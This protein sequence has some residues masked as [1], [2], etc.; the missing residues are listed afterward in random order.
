M[1]GKS[2][3]NRN[4]IPW[5]L[6]PI[7]W[8]AAIAA[9]I[10]GMLE[11]VAE[12]APSEAT[13]ELVVIAVAPVLAMLRFKP[14]LKL[15]KPPGR[16]AWISDGVWSIILGWLSLNVC[17]YIGS[18]YAELPP[19][20]H[21]EFSYLFQAKTLLA[22]RFSFPSH[23]VHPELFNQMHV[24]NEGRMA[25]RYYPG[26]GLWLAPFVAQ[27]HPYLAPAIAGA[28]ATV[29]VFWIGKEI[30]G[31][32]AGVVAGGVLAVS[33]GVTV[34]GNTLLAH[35]PT[36]LGE[37]LFLLG[38]TRWRRTR[39][40]LDAWMAGIGLS[41]AM[42]CRPLTAAAIGL[43]FGIDIALWLIR[44]DA[45][46]RTAVSQELPPP[47]PDHPRRWP[48]ILG[49]AAPLALGW[50]TMLAYN[51]DITGQ[52]LKSPYQLYTDVYTPRHVFGFNN[53]VRGEKQ[54]GPKV[55]DEYD[56][57]AENLGWRLAVKNLMTRWTSSW[58]WTLGFVPLLLTT[59]FYLG[60]SRWLDR[61]WNLIAASIVSLHVLHLPYWFVGL[62]GWHYVF[63]S[64]PL[65]CLLLG[66][67]TSLL[68]S[69]WKRQGQWLLIGWWFGIIG[70][71]LAGSYLS[72][73]P[74]P[75]WPKHLW[76]SRV[77]HGMNILEYPRKRHFEQRRWMEAHVGDEPALVL[78]DQKG[79]DLHMDMV[80]NDPGLNGKILVGRYFEGKTDAAQIQRDFPDRRVYVASPIQGIFRPVK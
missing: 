61:R 6:P 67:I 65:W 59:V 62:M 45:S 42:L 15:P 48:T 19:A 7:A 63:E 23:P 20:Y 10:L 73:I 40:G 34:F 56:R 35:H 31:R 36:L 75:D 76:C 49:F 78:W 44:G 22:G 52:W 24:L 9:C 50:G 18:P 60:L 43:P 5:W 58:I 12:W 77:Q 47:L 25:S 3:I 8:L 68:V 39:C 37:C 71:A 27:Q 26:T 74:R 14:S 55:I 32:L 1:S 38:V 29:L 2:V 54:L 51:H 46:S 72:P 70:V 17:L 64:A 28:L 13:I 33:P 53:V 21:D 11:R 30:A 66:A 57:W 80:V 41:F 4:F 69:C 16:A 79:T